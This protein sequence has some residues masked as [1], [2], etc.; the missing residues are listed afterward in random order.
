VIR[1]P[2]GLALDQHDMALVFSDRNCAARPSA[3]RSVALSQV[4]GTIL[5][6]N[7]Q[8]ALENVEQFIFLVV[9][10]PH[11]RAQDLRDLDVGVIELCHY[12]RR[13][14]FLE[15][16]GHRSWRDGFRHAR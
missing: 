15:R 11:E 7:A 3:R 8:P 16:G 9:G 10:V 1:V 14:V 13:P 12:A 6:L 2:G 5:E 4:N